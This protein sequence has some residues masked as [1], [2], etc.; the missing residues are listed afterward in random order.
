MKTSTFDLRGSFGTLD[1]LGVEKQ[2]LR[3]PGVTRVSANAAS[4][5]VTVSFDEA[6]TSEAAIEEKIAD[7]GF[8]CGGH[9]TLA[10]AANFILGIKDGKK[11]FADTALAMSKAFTLC[12]T[13]DE[14]R[15]VREEVA[16]FQAV[17]VLLTKRDI[18][19]QKKT[20]EA[21]ELAIHQIISAA[22]VSDEVVDIFD[23]VG[24]DKPNIGILDDAFLA[25]V[26]NLPER[27]LA[28][29]LLER[30]L[31]GEI[32][33]RFAGNVVQNKKF[34][35]LLADGGEARQVDIATRLGVAQPTVAKM[36]RRL[37]RDGWVVQRPYRGVFLTPEGEALAHASRQRHQTVERFLL[38]LGVDPD[39]ARRDAEGIE[40]HVS[41]QT[42]ALFEAFVRKAEGEAP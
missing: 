19:Q 22:V 33:A 41:E 2:L 30:L 37:A 1:H 39:T 27:N 17:K 14:A 25:E 32:K 26:C 24:L 3:V 12:C 31:E 10:G 23:A 29:E 28:V 18:S 9:K 21:R 7:C 40:H 11:R 16:F 8:H 20:D 4:D 5:S 6:R 13:L 15:A 34:S 36:L 35:D 42:L 38:A